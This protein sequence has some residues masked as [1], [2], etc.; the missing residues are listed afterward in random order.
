MHD[1]NPKA[2]WNEAAKDSDVRYKYI[3]DEWASTEK[4][5]DYQHEVHLYYA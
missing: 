2:F 3:A 4:F 5:L 1:Y